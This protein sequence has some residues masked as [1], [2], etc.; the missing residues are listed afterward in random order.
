MQPFAQVPNDLPSGGARAPEQTRREL[1]LAAEREIHLHGY[2]AASLARIIATTG[3]TK[4]ALYHHFPSK[5]ALGYA[6]LDE[7]WA[8]QLR[9][10]WVEPMIQSRECPVDLL[11]RL[12]VEAGQQ[13][14]QDDVRLGCPINNIAQE[15]SPIDE[16]FRDRVNALL[17]EWRGAI[18]EALARGQQ[19]GTVLARIQPEATATLLVASLE[20]CV[21]MAKNAQSKELLMQCGAGVID[22]LQSLRR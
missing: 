14:A 7:I 18:A 19:Q 2:Q 6:V 22:F 9:A 8:P 17:A 16:G 1:L 3:V 21:G 15:M 13:M 20:G 11:I 10:L 4:G 5:Q 12:I